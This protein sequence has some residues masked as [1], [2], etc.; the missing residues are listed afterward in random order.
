MVYD[1]PSIQRELSMITEIA[2]FKIR[3]EQRADFLAAIHQA[4][5]LHLSRSPGY[6]SHQ[7]LPCIETAGRVVLIVQWE[8]LEAHTVG[9]RQSSAFPEW[10]A[11]I[12]PFFMEPPQVEHFELSAA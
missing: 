4:A 1:A 9:F 8:S 10:R 5:R 2:D 6:V 12:G 3:P 7:I 11:L